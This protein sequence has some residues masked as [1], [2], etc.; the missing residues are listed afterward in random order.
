MLDEE[1][2]QQIPLNSLLY[3]QKPVLGLSSGQTRQIDPLQVVFPS[4]GFGLA[5][6]VTSPVQMDADV[7]R[8]NSAAVA[9]GP[10]NTEMDVKE[11]RGIA[12]TFV[13]LSLVNLIITCYLFVNA[14]IA[15]T[16]KVSPEPDDTVFPFVFQLVPH[17]RRPIEK[18]NFGFTIL[19]LIIGIFSAVF[20]QPLGL[21][22]FAISTVLNFLLGTI[23]LP[24]FAYATR[25]IFDV[26]MLYLALVFR[27]KLVFNFLPFTL[28]HIHRA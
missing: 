21:S 6:P 9:S 22:V 20:E 17:N 13:G 4:G 19:I 2:E 28:S 3:Y 27:S 1:N 24:Y 5:V 8:Y 10:E 26:W 16:S 15:D 12:F 7:T 11:R 25:Y 18:V 23:A 14:D